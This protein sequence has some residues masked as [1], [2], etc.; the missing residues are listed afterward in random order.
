MSVVSAST[1]RAAPFAQARF[2]FR[3]GL[4]DRIEIGRIG[5]REA[6]AGTRLDRCAHPTNLVGAQIIH[7]DDAGLAQRRHQH[8]FDIGQEGRTI[9]RPVDHIRRRQPADTQCRDERQ[10]FPMA[11]RNL[12][13]QAFTNGGTPVEPCHLGVDGCLVDE[14]EAA[15][16]Q[17]RLPGGQLGTRSRHIRTILLCRVQTFFLTVNLWRSKKRQ[18]E[19]MPALWAFLPRQCLE[20]ECRRGPVRMT[21]RTGRHLNE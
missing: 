8:L 21:S 5:R 2:Q 1:V 6:Q 7:E 20:D 9:H 15:R 12:G 19:S 17:L 14:D 4:L 11:A 13:H 10:R 3:I 18:I 16:L